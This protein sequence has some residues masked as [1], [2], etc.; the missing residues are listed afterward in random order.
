MED[1]AETVE[2][3]DGETDKEVIDD[4]GTMIIMYK[5]TEYKICEESIINNVLALLL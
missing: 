5:G 4:S 1:S 2:E 3:A